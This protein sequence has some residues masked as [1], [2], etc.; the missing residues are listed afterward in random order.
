MFLQSLGRR[1]TMARVVTR[2][3][4]EY[5]FG[6]SEVRMESRSDS[7]RTPIGLR[8]QAHRFSLPGH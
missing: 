6:T 2:A 8:L 7:I 1:L 5:Q 3:A 4:S